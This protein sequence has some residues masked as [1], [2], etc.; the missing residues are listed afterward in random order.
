MFSTFP[1]E[2]GH[3]RRCRPCAT[4]VYHHKPSV[5]RAEVLTVKPSEPVAR[6]E[7]EVRGV[8]AGTP[9]A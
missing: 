4:G 3:L 9:L 8:Q 6:V 1:A 5:A 7:V 2:L